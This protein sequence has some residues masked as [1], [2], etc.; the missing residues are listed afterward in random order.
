MSAILV[1]W[2]HFRGRKLHIFRD[3]MNKIFSFWLTTSFNIFQYFGQDLLTDYWHYIFYW[4][5]LLQKYVPKE[6]N[7]RMMKNSEYFNL[8]NQR[9]RKQAV[10]Y[11][12]RQSNERSIHTKPRLRCVAAMHTYAMLLH[13]GVAWKLNSFLIWNAV[14]LRWLAVEI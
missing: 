8:P 2:N 7:L 1:L 4:M 13:C 5:L 10:L 11:F 3:V 14:M 12:R 6:F 9:L